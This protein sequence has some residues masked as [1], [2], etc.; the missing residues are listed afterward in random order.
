MI[1]EVI[2]Q[3][4][5]ITVALVVASG[6]VFVIVFDFMEEHHDW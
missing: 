6:L 1:A 2:V 4:A 5:G 3:A